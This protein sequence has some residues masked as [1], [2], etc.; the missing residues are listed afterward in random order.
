MKRAASVM[1]F[2]AALAACGSPK[3]A[4]SPAAGAAADG[5]PAQQAAPPVPDPTSTYVDIGVPECDQYARRYLA[6]LER[7]PEA[8]RAM[9]RQSFDQTREVWSMTAE[10]PDRRAGLAASC[11]QQAE[12]SKAAMSRYDCEW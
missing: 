9:M 10:K 7:T 3:P 2:A 1:I 8:T 5:P 12:A 6:C 4:P 11:T